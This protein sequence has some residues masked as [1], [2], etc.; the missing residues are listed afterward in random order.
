[1][2]DVVHKAGDGRF[3]TVLLLLLWF[4]TAQ[5]C[6]SISVNPICPS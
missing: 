3:L 4:G 6:T 1:M 5:E 2:F